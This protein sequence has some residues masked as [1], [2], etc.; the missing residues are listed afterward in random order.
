MTTPEAVP[1]T[2]DLRKYI[3]T[4]LFGDRPHIRGKRIPVSFIAAN[5]EAN[6]WNISELAYE[7]TLP[8][9]EVLAALLFYR[10]HKD[11]IDSQDAEEEKLWN[12][13]YQPKM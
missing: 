1:A 12:E 10:E 6:H 13:M 8:E 9:E 4:R 5:S 7:F 11:E 2:T 3:E